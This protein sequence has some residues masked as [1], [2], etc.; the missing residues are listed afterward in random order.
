MAGQGE[1]HLSR[2]FAPG[3]AVLLGYVLLVGNPWV[4][5]DL[6][7]AVSDAD[8]V[9]RIVDVLVYYPSWHVDVD[10]LGPFLF[11]FT[12]LRTVLFAVLAVAGLSRMSRWLDENAGGAVRFVTTVGLTTLSAVAAGL[13]S[14]AVA[15]TLV[16]SREALLYVGPGPEQF[17]LRQLS[18]SAMFGVLIGLVLGAV[19]IM[20]RRTAVHRERRV[21]AP[22]S[23]W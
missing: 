19:V 7:V 8:S 2:L 20:Q 18:M 16:D 22:K 4:N 13:T 11:W 3:V 15:V 6:Q 5:R 14:A 9:I 12:N 17:F 1:P 21:N 23:F 10:H